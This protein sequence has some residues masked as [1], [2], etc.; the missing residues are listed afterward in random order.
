MAN[1]YRDLEA[2][3]LIPSGLLNNYG[4]TL[5]RFPAAVALTGLGAI[6]D[7]LVARNKWTAPKVQQELRLLF[8]TNEERYAYLQV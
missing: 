5:F 6:S 2:P 3:V 4:R 8:R 1:A 7:A